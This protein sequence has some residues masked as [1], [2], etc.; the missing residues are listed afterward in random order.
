MLSFRPAW[1]G[2]GS[3]SDTRHP[4]VP[5][6]AGS[7]DLQIAVAAVVVITHNRPSYLSQT[8]Q[9]VLNHMT[10][11][12]K[13]PVYVSQV[14]GALAPPGCVRAPCPAQRWVQRLYTLSAGWQASPHAENTMQK[15][16]QITPL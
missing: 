13:C 3:N 4:P 5:P 2:V 1:H 9:S 15:T 8:V 11:P 6:K 10:N 16:N 12:A 7:I 14:R